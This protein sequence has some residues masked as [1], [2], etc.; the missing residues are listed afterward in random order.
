MTEIIEG[1]IFFGALLC[2]F[3][4]YVYIALNLIKRSDAGKLNRFA[5]VILYAITSPFV[6]IVPILICYAGRFVGSVIGLN[7]LPKQGV[8]DGVMVGLGFLG[9]GIGMA[10]TMLLA[11]IMLFKAIFA[12]RA[13]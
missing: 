12:V 13:E 9:M 7:I 10:A 11:A 2:G 6:S 3:A 1:I 8:D 5:A 4:A